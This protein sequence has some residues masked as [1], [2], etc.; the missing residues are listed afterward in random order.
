MSAQYRPARRRH[1]RRARRPLGSRSRAGARR[2]L[3]RSVRGSARRSRPTRSLATLLPEEV[4]R[5]YDALAIGRLERP[6]RDR[7]G[8]PHRPVRARRPPDRHAPTDHRGDGGRGRP[9]RRDRSR[10]PR[11][12]GGDLARRRGRDRRRS[13]NA[14]RRSST[15]ADV[16]DGP[17]V[18]LVNALMDQAIRDRRVR[19]ARRALLD[20]CRDPAPHRRRVARLVRGAARAPAPAR[21]PAED[22]RRPR[23]RADPTSQD[24][25]FSVTVQGRPVDVRVVTVPT[26]V[27]RVGDPAAPRPDARRARRVEPRAQ[28][29]GG[30]ALPSAVPRV[31]GRGVHHRPDGIGQDVD[32][33]LGA[34]ADQHAC[35]R[36]SSRSRIPVEFRLDGIKQIQINPAGRAHVPDHAAFDPARRPRRRVHR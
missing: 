28:P 22:P 4:A 14:S 9:P 6:A 35:R 1:P 18:R 30:G 16:D 27:G 26:V 29:R 2:S 20:A 21:E 19:P 33:L 31:A 8:E 32:R 25:R 23:H 13:A 5:R 17:V 12:A 24:G 36:A 10:V 11:V 15:R 3:R 34:V 7:D